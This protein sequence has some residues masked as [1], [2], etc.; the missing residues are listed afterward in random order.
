ARY[1]GIQSVADSAAPDV[2]ASVPADAVEASAVVPPPPVSSVAPLDDSL[3]Q[4]LRNIGAPMPAI[5][6]PRMKTRR[7]IVFAPSI[8]SLLF[9]FDSLTAVPSPQVFS[10]G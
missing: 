2:V 7:S 10:A 8:S 5:A 9:A 1:V 3:P 6:A 4:A